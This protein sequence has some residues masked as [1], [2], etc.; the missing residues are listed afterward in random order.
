MRPLFRSLLVILAFALTGPSANAAE[1][2]L[3]AGDSSSGTLHRIDKTT[4]STQ[5]STAVTINGNSA[6]WIKGLAAQ[7]GT[8]DLYAI[9]G[10][11]ATLDGVVDFK[12]ATIAPDTGVATEIGLLSDR[13]SGLAWVVLPPTGDGTLQPIDALMGVTGN[14]ASTPESLFIIDHTNAGSALFMNLTMSGPG[15]AVAFNTLD[16]M[17]YR[18]SGSSIPDT[19]EGSL[20]DFEQIDLSGPSSTPI[21]LTGAQFSKGNGLVF[22]EA[23]GGFFFAAE[24]A[25]PPGDG[26]TGATELFSLN[27]GGTAAP[28]GAIAAYFGGMAFSFQVPVELQSFSIE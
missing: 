23:T 6:V 13:F 1:P 27:I 10:E 3:Y 8:G 14:G 15:E 28:V 22:D 4:G 9:V 11:F 2:F 16:G 20:I 17:L 12:L 26:G 21:P 5:L 18:L 19:P 24:T 7:P 25:P